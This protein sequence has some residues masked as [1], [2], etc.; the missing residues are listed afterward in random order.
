[1]LAGEAAAGL[2]VT[3]GA[4]M[5]PLPVVPCA[6]VAVVALI[7]HTRVS[8]EERGVAAE[9]GAMGSGAPA[10]LFGFTPFPYD[11]TLEALAKTRAIPKARVV[12]LALS[13]LATDRK[14]LAPATGEQERV[15]MPE[16][17]RGV[18]LDDA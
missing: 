11:S 6:V 9:P 1:E 16:A 17:L 5:K 12:H 4:D 10:T 8:C 13:P 2:T 15:P 14:S 3:R 7:G 18:P